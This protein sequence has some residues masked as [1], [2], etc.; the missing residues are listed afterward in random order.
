M[1]AG[2]AAFFAHLAWTGDTDIHRLRDL[3]ISHDAK[4]GVL[5]GLA[6]VSLGMVALAPSKLLAMVRPAVL[7]I[8]PGYA[9]VPYGLGL[10]KQARLSA[11]ESLVVYGDGGGPAGVLHVRWKGGRARLPESWFTS[12]EEAERALTALRGLA[13]TPS[14]APGALPSR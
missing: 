2:C 11:G 7:E 1:F 12:P 6:T 14:T 10:R 9:V 8:G 4:V 3:P 13:L 5:W